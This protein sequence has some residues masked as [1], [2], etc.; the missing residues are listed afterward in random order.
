MSQ[1][2][3]QVGASLP[4]ADLVSIFQLQTTDDEVVDGDNA[5]MTSESSSDCDATDNEE[6]LP[7]EEDSDDATL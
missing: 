1:R 5:S 3:C 2:L 7:V 6:A 4:V